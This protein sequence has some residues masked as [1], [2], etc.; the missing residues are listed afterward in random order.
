MKSSNARPTLSDG[1]GGKMKKFIS[2]IIALALSLTL[3][4]SFSACA[5]VENGVKIQRM[6]MT[7]EYTDADG[8]S[9]ERTVQLKLYLNNAPKTTARFM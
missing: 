2:L 8:Q 9:V 4:M 6:K 7:L 3:I 5:E 1:R